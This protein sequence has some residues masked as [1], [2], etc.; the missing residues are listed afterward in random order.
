MLNRQKGYTSSKTIFFSTLPNKIL[1]SKRFSP[2]FNNI[3]EQNGLDK[4]VFNNVNRL[5]HSFS[6][7]NTVTNKIK[8]F[9]QL[10]AL[11]PQILLKQK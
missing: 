2:I 1:L 7:N 5:N 8:H 4:P 6:M 9:P 10:F 3:S 11:G